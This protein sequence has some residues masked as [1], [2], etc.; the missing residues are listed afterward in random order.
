MLDH[1]VLILFTPEEL[2]QSRVLAYKHGAEYIRALLLGSCGT[3]VWKS[4][5]ERRKAIIISSDA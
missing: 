1:D 3:S 5:L 4:N 2:I